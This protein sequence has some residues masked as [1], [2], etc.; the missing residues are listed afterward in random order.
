MQNIHETL[1]TL[2]AAVKQLQQQQQSATASPSNSNSSI[3]TINS[4]TVSQMQLIAD[5]V[6]PS[7]WRRIWPTGP[8]VCVDFLRAVRQRATAAQQR[9][10]LALSGTGTHFAETMRLSDCFN[11]AAYLAALKLTNAAELNASAGDLRLHSTL[12]RST[13]QGDRGTLTRPSV[14]GL[15]IDGAAF[16]ANRVVLVAG[17]N[18]IDSGSSSNNSDGGDPVPA[19]QLYYA[20]MT[21]ATTATTAVELPVYTSDTREH[22]VCVL[23]VETAAEP[24]AIG[25]AGVALVLKPQYV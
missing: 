25:I 1:I 22:L 13:A 12:C 6:V 7:D 17:S 16:R 5:N 8:R 4:I 24:E 23:D 21:L 15:Q 14:Q 2:H 19:F 20:N 3:N 18:G 9:F 11:L 10:A